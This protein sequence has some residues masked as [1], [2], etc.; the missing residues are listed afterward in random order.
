MKSN[1]IGGNPSLLTSLIG[2]FRFLVH[3]ITLLPKTN[4]ALQARLLLQLLNYQ[5][6]TYYLFLTSLA[7]QKKCIQI[8]QSGNFLAW[9]KRIAKMFRGLQFMRTF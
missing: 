6:I 4:M 2:N 8:S 1:Y 5:F 3:S 9:K 7:V